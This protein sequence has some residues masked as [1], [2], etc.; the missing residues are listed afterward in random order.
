MGIKL[1][2]ASGMRLSKGDSVAHP[3]SSS[4]HLPGWIGSIP[5]GATHVDEP[6]LH[7]LARP[8]NTLLVIAETEDVRDVV[9]IVLLVAHELQRDGPAPAHT[10]ELETGCGEYGIDFPVL[11]T[12]GVRPDGVAH[13]T[14]GA[15]PQLSIDAVTLHGMEKATHSS[16][17]G[18]ATSAHAFIQSDPKLYL[19][20]VAA[21][22]DFKR[23]LASYTPLLCHSHTNER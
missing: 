13:L 8:P 12:H 1:R 23:S 11:R 22:H 9:R 4:L 20:A 10:D 2:H 18:R 14:V 5:H 19:K 6:F 21:M 16:D 17:T 3:V 7:D 15:M